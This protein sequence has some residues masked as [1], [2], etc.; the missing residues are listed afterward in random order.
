[1]KV[2]GLGGDVWRRFTIRRLTVSD[3]KGVWLSAEGLDLRWSY[4]ALVRRRLQVDAASIGKVTVLRRPT[5]SAKGPPSAGLPL[6]INVGQVRFQLETLP[7]FSQRYGLYD[8]RGKLRLERGDRGQSGEVRISS[9]TH[10]GDYLD[11]GFDVSRARPLKILADGQEA[12]GGALGG[13]LGLPADQTFAVTAR[14]IGTP[15][16]GRLD[17]RLTSGRRIPLDAHGG[18]TAA[19]KAFQCLSL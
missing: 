19:T 8:V 4:G 15:T 12:R 13:A 7:A 10:L 2:E 14:A 17:V 5:L 16:G 1:M 6:T 11:L 9:L 18:W 3:E